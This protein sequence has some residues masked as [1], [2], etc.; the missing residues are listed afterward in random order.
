LDGRDTAGG[1]T[2]YEKGLIWAVE[3]GI[4]DGTA[5]EASITREQLA[6]MLYRYADSPKIGAVSLNGF[7]DAD[8][9]SDWAKNAINW[10]VENGILTGKGGN[11]LDPTGNASRA[12]VAA[13]LE[14][15]IKN[16]M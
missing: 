14:R 5:P 15:F 7:S 13:M 10:A 16:A 2:W 11:V 3:K 9:V 1:A 6:A 4:S 12:E 8:K